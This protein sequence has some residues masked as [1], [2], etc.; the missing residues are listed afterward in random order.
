MT[1]STLAV[2]RR[3]HHPPVPTAYRFRGFDVLPHA[4]CSRA[5]ERTS[6]SS[7]LCNDYH[8]AMTNMEGA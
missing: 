8:F 1:Y 5:A 3:G 7:R 6:P 4:S 2:P